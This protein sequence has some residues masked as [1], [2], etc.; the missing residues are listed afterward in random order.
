MDFIIDLYERLLKD[1]TNYIFEDVRKRIDLGIMWIFNNYLNL[2]M[3]QNHKHSLDEQILKKAENDEIVELKSEEE[4]LAEDLKLKENE[5]QVFR[6]VK[7]YELDYDRTLY[8]IL[9][10]LQQRQDPRDL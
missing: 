1:L 5:E 2:K 7:K 9:F 3:A 6:S 4:K 8:T 10:N